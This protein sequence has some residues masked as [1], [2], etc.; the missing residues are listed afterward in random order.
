MSNPPHRSHK[1]QK[2]SVSNPNFYFNQPQTKPET[3]QYSTP[4]YHQQQPQQE[5]PES[6]QTSL[7]PSVDQLQQSHTINE[8]V[9]PSYPTRTQQKL[10]PPRESQ[11]QE[12]KS[13]ISSLKRGAT[14]A[15]ETSSNPISSSTP[16][17]SIYYQ[18]G[19]T[20]QDSGQSFSQHQQYQP[21]PQIAQPS[22]YQHHPSSYAPPQS[23]FSGSIPSN[24][25][26][27]PV[28]GPFNFNSQVSQSQSN[29]YQPDNTTNN[30]YQPSFSNTFY[31]T[32][33]NKVQNLY[34]S[35]GYLRSGTPQQ[36]S[37]LAS[38]NIAS[39]PSA[40][41]STSTSR[42]PVSHNK[43]NLSISSHLTLFTLGNPSGNNSPDPNRNR[44]QSLPQQQ[45]QQPSILEALLSELV[46]VDGS[47]INVYLLSAIYKIN[48]PFPLDDFYNLLYNDED[49]KPFVSNFNFAQK[50]DRTPITPQGS[51][52]FINIVDELLNTFKDP[53]LLLE[54]F[55][56]HEDKE[57]KFGNIN[58]HELLRTFLA[59]KILHDMMIQLPLTNDE[60]PQDY[61]IPRLSL[62]KTYFIICQKLIA[63]YPSSSNTTNEQQ[64]LI[65]GQSKLGKLI[66]LVYPNLLIKRLGS[67]GESK[68]N[69]LGVIWNEHIID[70]TFKRLCEDHDIPELIELFDS[71][72]G[73]N[74]FMTQ[75]RPSVVESTS[76]TPKKGHH[77]HHHHHRRSS[78]KSKIK[79]SNILEPFEVPPTQQ[80]QDE[81]AIVDDDEKTNPILSPRL[82]FIKPSLMYPDVSN[83]TILQN[84]HRDDNWFSSLLKNS[85]SQ[86][87]QIN[88]DL[89][90]SF[91]LT[92]TNLSNK[93]SLL[94]NF[95]SSFIKPLSTTTYNKIKNID[96]HLYLIIILELLPHFLLIKPS[97]DL[98][99]LKNLR[100]NLLHLINNL[101]NEL[102]IVDSDQFPVT[103]STIFLI[104]LK[105]MM[106]LND[107]LITFI[108]LLNNKSTKVLM[109]KD[110]ENF[111]KTYSSTSS[112]SA[113]QTAIK[114]ETSIPHTDDS[115]NQFF[116]NITPINDLNFNF[117]KDILSNDLIYT[118]IGFNYDPLINNEI[119]SPISMNFITEEINIVDDFF[120]NDLLNFLNS[121]NYPS[122]IN[123][124]KNYYDYNINPTNTS[125]PS[126]LNNPS[127]DIHLDHLHSSSSTETL[128]NPTN[129]TSTS[130]STLF[131]KPKPTTDSSSAATTTTSVLTPLEYSRLNSLFQLIDEKLLS[132]HFKTKYPIIIFN[133][134]MT[135]IL[136]DILKYI[137]LNQQQQQSS[138]QSKNY[139]AEQDE[140]NNKGGSSIS[141][142][143]N[144]SSDNNSENSFGNW[145]VFNSFI[146]EYLN[147]MG[148]IV[149]LNDSLR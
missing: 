146:Q 77:H 28:S 38:S 66:K 27:P 44:D 58:Y 50:M 102:K 145:W 4:S 103:N 78:S 34:T 72:N 37:N 54:Y 112:S 138:N 7:L 98:N 36:Y 20:Y 29:F 108:K 128:M 75:Q 59:I 33:G 63:T 122:N 60:D 113:N 126:I 49:N 25:T 111:L 106:N 88:Q 136:N 16:P 15:F 140:G 26:T 124:S 47:N 83:F 68:Y 110:I 80:E 144:K 90:N 87:Q 129:A 107:L 116:F 51:S 32:G 64:K 35:S 6:Q 97:S 148:E 81:S 132:M 74:P 123:T 45:S 118:L 5:Q 137:F 141:R 93:T 42:Q 99:L 40:S 114:M 61:T 89:I 46:H 55:P 95:I 11:P 143:S 100:I 147:L 79:L 41:A 84:L 71:E 3:S 1:R 139:N 52:A 117:Q 73:T 125:S 142:L 67:R 94:N 86:C 18:Q 57:N 2:S 10:H 30:P 101:N 149:G 19:S 12:V 24:I 130:S 134:Y 14:A 17:S 85:Y 48:M 82:S 65:L 133:N 43:N 109:S 135:Y 96:L 92:N 127:L 121:N 70:D 21:F 76:T 39:N 62:Y 9:F 131:S 104:I 119:K 56:D 69:Y 13:Q 31:S 8:D 105:K 91:L 115:S 120:K 23:S 22:Y 53:N